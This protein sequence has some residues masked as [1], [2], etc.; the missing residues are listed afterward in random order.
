MI[1]YCLDDDAAMMKMLYREEKIVSTDEKIGH[2]VKCKAT[3]AMEATEFW[4]SLSL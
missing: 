1:S 3:G 2:W 4:D